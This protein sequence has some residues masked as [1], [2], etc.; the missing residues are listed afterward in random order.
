MCKLDKGE[1]VLRFKKSSYNNQDNQGLD[2]NGFGGST[3]LS[4]HSP[5]FNLTK[6]LEMFDNIFFHH[7]SA[8]KVS[9]LPN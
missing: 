8:S 2:K 3:V 7:S 1:V 9:I 6:W 5:D 4:Y